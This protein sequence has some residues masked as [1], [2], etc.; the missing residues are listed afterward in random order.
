MRSLGREHCCARSARFTHPGNGW[1]FWRLDHHPS[2]NPDATAPP[3]GAHGTPDPG[4]RRA[5][6]QAS[7]RRFPV[8][9]IFFPHMGFAA[10]KGGSSGLGSNGCP[11]CVGSARA[12]KAPKPRSGAPQAQGLTARPRPTPSWF[13]RTRAHRLPSS[14]SF[15]PQAG[16][17]GPSPVLPC[18]T[19]A[20]SPHI[21]SALEAP[22][23]MIPRARGHRA[24][25]SGTILL[26]G[27]SQPG[28]FAATTRP[29]PAFRSRPGP[30]EGRKLQDYALSTAPCGI[31]PCL[32]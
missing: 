32:T 10:V 3:E 22:G 31:T 23:T 16:V 1:R 30:Q 2:R 17:Q 4:L 13:D 8:R 20:A 5:F 24:R 26:D 7:R 25:K 29:S 19:T 6:C 28:N 11:L 15:C 27:M 21:R 9:L 18:D 12:V 14:P